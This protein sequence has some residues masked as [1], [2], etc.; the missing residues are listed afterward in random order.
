MLSVQTRTVA[1]LGFSALERATFEAFF[2]TALARAQRTEGHHAQAYVKVDELEQARIVLVDADRADAASDP[3]IQP[4][5]CIFLGAQ[6]RAG[7]LAHLTRPINMM[8]L[9]RVLDRCVADAPAPGFAPA[10]AAAIAPPPL[11]PPTPR[12]A[13]KAS[14]QPASV[15]AA[16]NVD[17]ILVVDDS[18]IALRFMARCLGEFGFEVHLA[19][20][21][22]EALARIAEQHFEFV[23][24]DVTMP[25][26][27][28]YQACKQIKKFNYADGRRAP[29]VVMLTSRDGMVDKMRGTFA[30]CDAY[31]TKPLQQQALLKVVG[32]HVVS[33]AAEAETRRD[34]V[35]LD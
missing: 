15:P 1:L 8:A 14:S 34:A 30:G 29:A 10:A 18:D 23:F 5:R 16:A 33:A 31:L 35:A 20:S 7:Q 19:R 24:M 27:D 21:G 25:G 17:H 6:G 11:P 2:R 4:A 9:L 28:G 26:L 3:R 13:P 32:D 22:Q 12:A